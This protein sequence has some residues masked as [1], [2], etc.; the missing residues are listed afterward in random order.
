MPKITL[1]EIEYYYLAYAPILPIKET[2]GWASE[3]ITFNDGSE[4]THRFR[5]TPREG[6]TLQY[7]IHEKDVPEFSATVEKG[8]RQQWLVPAW[9]ESQRLTGNDGTKVFFDAAGFW[10]DLGTPVLIFHPHRGYQIRVIEEF[11]VDGLILDDYTPAPPNSLIMPMR[12][13]VLNG[14]VQR[15]ASG[16]DGTVS[17][18]YTFTDHIIMPIDPARG[19]CNS[20]LRST[21]L[22]IHVCMNLGFRLFGG[23]PIESPIDNSRRIG[24]S[25]ALLQLAEVIE[26]RGLLVDFRFTYWPGSP[27]GVTYAAVTRGQLEALAASILD[28]WLVSESQLCD[29]ALA[30]ISEFTRTALP[31]NS[32]R[33]DFVIFVTGS[34]ANV[35]DP[36]G[37]DEAGAFP[38][39]ADI[40]LQEAPYDG[41][42][43]VDIYMVRNEP[44]DTF[45]EFLQNKDDGPSGVYSSPTDLSEAILSILDHILYPTPCGVASM[46]RE[47]LAIN[48]S[49]PHSV[50][51]AYE[52]A[53]YDVG[54]L[55]HVSDWSQSKRGV[56]YSTMTENMAEWRELLDFYDAHSGR[57]GTFTM[58]S[59]ER[60]LILISIGG[61]RFDLTVVDTT[62]TNP[63]IRSAVAIRFMDD[64]WQYAD[65]ASVGTPSGGNV[66][67]TLAS[68]VEEKEINF[69]GFLGTYR[70]ASD[71]LEA[72]WIDR[73]V[74]QVSY[75]L[76]EVEK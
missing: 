17:L 57:D 37:A 69:I 72:T 30:S 7:I 52:T 27:T 24:V 26:E 39:I 4:E 1:G 60:E 40:V 38:I 33:K 67:I 9:A 15:E 68:A 28:L 14:D 48:D 70:F 32:R 3:V 35:A 63:V 58:P 20:G 74:A 16:A 46:L 62:F 2:R 21:Y 50:T 10:A 12:R 36:S 71:K 31:N 55:V 75:S 56:T 8:I 42:K 43:A 64:T 54:G 34:G 51:Q 49:A 23:P 53:D 73:G 59:F 29:S 76:I 19:A 44:P 25:N 18:S 45:I 5:S 11:A 66:T 6:V 41:Y 13:G 61:G 65:I 47:P 22:G